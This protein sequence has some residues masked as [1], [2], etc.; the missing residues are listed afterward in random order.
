MRILLF[1]VLLLL[2]AFHLRAQVST[3]A[4]SGSVTDSTGAA[5]PGATVTITHQATGITQTSTTDNSGFFSAEG[6]NVGQYTIDVTKPGFQ[7]SVTRDIQVDPGQRRANSIVMQV[8]SSTQTVTVTANAEQVNTE[9]SESGG[10]LTSQQI[11][12]GQIAALLQEAP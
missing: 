11:N 3:G 10:T 1:A 12:S 2:P 5:I 9:T 8:G 6:L 4:I 7:E